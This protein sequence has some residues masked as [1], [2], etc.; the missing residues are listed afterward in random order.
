MFNL[1]KSMR[2]EYT[3]H[4]GRKLVTPAFYTDEK[5]DRFMRQWDLKMGFE[6]L[7]LKHAGILALTAGDKRPLLQQMKEEVENYIAWAHDKDNQDTHMKD[8]YITDHKPKAKKYH[9]INAEDDQQFYNYHAALKQYYA[10]EGEKKVT[11]KMKGLFDFKRG[12]IMQRAFD[13]L[14]YAEKKEDGTVF[15]QI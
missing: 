5:M 1:L 11:R 15:F 14:A 4:W 13:P 2:R 12:S 10:D 3:P 6:S 7:K 8:T 9:T